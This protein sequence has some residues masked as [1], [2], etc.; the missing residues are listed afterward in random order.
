MTGEELAAKVAADTEKRRANEAPMREAMVYED[1]A[2][3]QIMRAAIDAEESRLRAE[4]GHLPLTAEPG[5]VI[6]FERDGKRFGGLVWQPVSQPDNLIAGDTFIQLH[7][8]WI[9]TLEHVVSIRR[10]A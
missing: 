7:G 4:Y 1:T 6:E 10:H 3:Q 9:A 2:H 8:E 5:D